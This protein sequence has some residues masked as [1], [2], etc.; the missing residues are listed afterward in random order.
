MK[1]SSRLGFTLIELLVVIAIIAILAAILFPVFAQAREKARQTSCLSNCKQIGT[2]QMMY[3]QDYDEVYPLWGYWNPMQRVNGWK[4]TWVQ[5]LQPYAKN[6][7]IFKCPSDSND[8]LNLYWDTAD[9]RASWT[10]SSYWQNAYIT[11]WSGASFGMSSVSLPE[12]N[13]PATTVTFCE[14]PTN[15]G[16]HTWPGPPS[17]WCG[18][19]PICVKSQERHGGGMNNVFADSHAKWFK[20]SQFKTTNTDFASDNVAGIG[21]RPQKASNDGSNPWWRL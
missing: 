14:G 19:N 13:Y 11:R 16:Q 20:P 8:G 4:Q 6:M 9:A 18:T 2:A 12:I 17:E 15:N 5:I 10:S 3:V 7:Q 21:G 1:K